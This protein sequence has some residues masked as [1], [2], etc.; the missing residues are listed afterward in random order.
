MVASQQLDN[1]HAVIYRED[2]RR[3]QSRKQSQCS[4]VRQSISNQPFGRLRQK[5]A[6]HPD[7]HGSQGGHFVESSAQ[8]LPSTRGCQ[9]AVL[10]LGSERLSRK[11][12]R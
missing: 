6:K 4:Q 5:P 8:E 12:K 3:A 11:G 9:Q 7:D 10:S 2:D 1:H